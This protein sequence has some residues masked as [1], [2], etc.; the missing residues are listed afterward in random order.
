M[1]KIR[2]LF[3]CLGNICRSPAAEAIFKTITE[4]NNHNFRFEVDSAGT[5]AHHAGE[6]A[7]PRMRS[8]G[9]ELGYELTSISR[10]FVPLDFSRFDFILVMDNQNLKNV[11]RQA[12]SDEE[13]IKV[14]KLTDYSSGE[15]SGFDEVPDP[16]Y[17]GLDGFKISFSL[18]E[19]CCQNLY[20][21]LIT[22]TTKE[23]S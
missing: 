13:I 12:V 6:M 17:G 15:F 16:Y 11:L 4:K 2:V 23:L 21:E 10:K 9:V 14:K 3:V 7:D 5:S 18:L 19:N 22:K 20:D 1:S 8:M